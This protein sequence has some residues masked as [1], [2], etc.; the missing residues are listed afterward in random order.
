MSVAYQLARVAIAAC[1]SVQWMAKRPHLLSAFGVEPADISDEILHEAIKLHRRM[2]PLLEPDTKFLKG[3]A[4][5]AV[6]ELDVPAGDVPSP[7]PNKST[8]GTRKQVRAQ[9]FG[10]SITAVLRWMGKEGW[11]FED[12]AVVCATIGAAKI[13]DVTI[14]LQLKAGKDGLRGPAAPITASQAKQLRQM[15]K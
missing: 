3:L 9:V 2:P 1:H 7:I 15:S 4:K 5:G 13:A 14:R 8:K 6:T 11:T 10:Y 12:A